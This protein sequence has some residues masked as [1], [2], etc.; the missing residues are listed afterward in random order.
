MRTWT[1]VKKVTL[2]YEG[3]PHLDIV[4]ELE[5]TLERVPWLVVDVIVTS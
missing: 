5:T 4:E 3:D 1:L 2:I